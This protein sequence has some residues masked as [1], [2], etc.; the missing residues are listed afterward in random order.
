MVTVAVNLLNR[1]AAEQTAI[2]FLNSLPGGFIIRV[3]DKGKP[4]IERS[5]IRVEL[6]QNKGFKKPGGMPQMPGGRAN[7]RGTL[8]YVIFYC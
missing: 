7:I 2:R 6:L 1:R 8:N 3:K 5:V 4:G